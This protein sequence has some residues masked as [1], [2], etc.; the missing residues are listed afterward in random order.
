MRNLSASR[1]TLLS[2]DTIGPDWAAAE[3]HGK[4]RRPGIASAA[5]SAF[6]Q[7]CFNPIQK[8]PIPL[9]DN[10]KVL[11][12]LGYGYPLY[13]I[14]VKY[15]IALMLLELL[16]YSGVGIIY[17]LD[18]SYAICERGGVVELPGGYEGQCTSWLVRF[19]RTEQTVST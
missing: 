10:S 14:F 9:C 17:A 4:A 2:L 8:E 6:C 12:N 18:S 1:N 16:S 19:M 11:S 5:N 7:C 3:N 15:L 13:F